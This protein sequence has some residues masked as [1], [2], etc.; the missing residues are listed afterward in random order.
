MVCRLQMLTR[1]V[2]NECTC[3][4]A[5][6]PQESP[7]SLEQLD[8][9]DMDLSFDWLDSVISPLRGLTSLQLCGLNIEGGFPGVFSSQSR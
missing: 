1:L 6:R 4:Y 5:M 3:L 7:T 2:M 9:C 8:L